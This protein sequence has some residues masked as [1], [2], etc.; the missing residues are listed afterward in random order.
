MIIALDA[1]GGDF[2]PTSAIEGGIMAARKFDD[3][4]IVLI[5]ESSII[6][7]HLAYLE[8]RPKNIQVIHASEII[9][10]GEHPALALRQKPLSSI[11]IGFNMLAAGD[12]NAFCSAGNTGAMLVGALLSVKAITGVMRPAIAGYVPKPDGTAG[13]MLDAG[14]NAELK[15][16]HLVQFAELGYIYAQ[17]VMEIPN[18]TVG[19]M[20]MGEE[21][22]KG[23]AVLQSV[24]KSL[25]T[26]P[27]I[28]FIGNLEGRDVFTSKADVII[29]DGLV[30]NVI[31]KL[32]E[33]IYELLMAGNTP[34]D[35]F[36]TKLNYELHGGSPIVGVNGNVV[37]GH[38][39][40]TPLAIKN[41][42]AQCRRMIRADVNNK[43]SKAIESMANPPQN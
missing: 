35:S 12:V 25:K 29:T 41:M 4:T 15:P 31:L 37:I 33:S 39:R 6:E 26:H 5:G 13:I 10:M 20:N 8:D 3:C 43:I 42:V 32:A 17:S 36:F 9:E 23:S 1:M 7:S 38:G 11:A 16:E 14:A 40:S 28:N 27:F 30:G 21:E 34:L 24:Y 22:G 19:L 18:P 2:A